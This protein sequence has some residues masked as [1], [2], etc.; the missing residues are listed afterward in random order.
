MSELRTSQSIAE[1][2]FEPFRAQIDACFEFM[3]KESVHN[4][5]LISR[6]IS[7]QAI[8]LGDVRHATEFFLQFSNY[9]SSA[10][11]K[12]DEGDIA[13]VDLIAVLD[14]VFGWINQSCPKDGLCYLWISWP[15]VTNINLLSAA[16]H[17]AANNSKWVMQR[18]VQGA[19][20][21]IAFE[22][23]ER[24][25]RL[26]TELERI[27]QVYPKT[28][29]VSCMPA[30][31]SDIFKFPVTR[32]TLAMFERCG[33]IEALVSRKV[34]LVLA[35]EA[36]LG[37]L[38]NP[39][40][41]IR[42]KA[43]P[44]LNQL[45]AHLQAEG[46]LS[47]SRLSGQKNAALK[48]MLS[49]LG[50]KSP[51]VR[52]NEP[53]ANM[54][55]SLIPYASADIGV[56]GFVIMGS[57]CQQPELFWPLKL[58][59]TLNRVEFRKRMRI[60]KPFEAPNDVIHVLGVESF[61]TPGE[62]HKMT[63]VRGVLMELVGALEA[64]RQTQ[65]R[66]EYDVELLIARASLE[67]VETSVTKVT[68]QV[69]LQD[70]L[71]N[72]S[73]YVPANLSERAFIYLSWLNLAKPPVWPANLV[74][75]FNKTVFKKALREICDIEYHLQIVKDLGV[76]S[77]FNAREINLMKGAVLNSALGL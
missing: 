72:L 3:D 37:L 28:K 25:G 56:E 27:E 36:V 57:V 52:T 62:L 31:A 33:G 50:K 75:T 70:H 20:A 42:A 13:T 68:K 40:L 65:G 12:L 74:N 39:E 8:D 61:Y 76:Q 73:P 22:G 43:Y 7:S 19:I 44:L 69:R 64:L 10:V 6:V 32:Q 38:N 30:M 47:E 41:E 66:A 77:F 4:L 63:G 24:L 45:W 16:F 34:D 51:L 14:K 21:C 58:H 29:L 17:F 71:L 54:I 48:R 11:A 55:R 1:A 60:G 53:F 49:T 18:S 35:S 59:T 67:T 2:A 46:S 5:I 23:G 15:S 26:V 9:L